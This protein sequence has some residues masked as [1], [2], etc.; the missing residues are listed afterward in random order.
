[1][2]SAIKDLNWLLIKHRINHKVATLV[3]K[4]L[5]NQAPAYLSNTI[6]IKDPNVHNLRSN[7]DAF[8]LDIPSTACRTFADRSFSVYGPMIW[9]ALPLEI[10][11]ADNVDIFKKRLKTYYFSFQ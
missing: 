2:R 7:N 10:R 9:N 3:Y 6:K 11:K 8:K 4:C 1:M 5:R